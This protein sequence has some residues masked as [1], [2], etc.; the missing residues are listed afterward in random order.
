MHKQV[1]KSRDQS[2]HNT[3][4]PRETRTRKS[5]TANERFHQKSRATI[6]D[7]ALDRT[8]HLTA[9]QSKSTPCTMENA[10][11]RQSQIVS[12]TFEEDQPEAAATSAAPTSTHRLQFEVLDCIETRTVTTTTTTKRTYPP[13][14]VRE[15]RPLDSL[16]TKEYPLSTTPVPPE[17]SHFT[18]EVPMT[19]R[20]HED[21]AEQVQMDGDKVL[22]RTELRL[23]GVWF[24]CCCTDESCF[25]FGPTVPC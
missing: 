1:T 16:D 17:F 10:R 22:V 24:F 9:Q 5:P 20:C 23:V 12:V 6:N 18:F 19:E 15:P 14:F 4:R 3:T 8:V 11:P 2:A 21:E 13:L 25:F 7:N